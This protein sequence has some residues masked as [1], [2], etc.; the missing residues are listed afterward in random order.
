MAFDAAAYLAQNPDVAAD[1]YYALNP[2]AHWLQH[3]Q[4]EGRTGGTT[5]GATSGGN[6]VPQEVMDYFAGGANQF[7]RYTDSSGYQWIPQ[8][9]GFSGGAGESGDQQFTGYRRGEYAGELNDP[10]RAE[11]TNNYYGTD[12]QYSYTNKDD[13]GWLTP[14]TG[15]LAVASLGLGAQYAAAAGAAEAGA[16]G[17]TYGGAT[18]GGAGL[19]TGA[20]TGADMA[21]FYGGLDGAATLGGGASVGGGAALGAGTSAMGAGAG[22]GYL[23]DATAAGY[24]GLDAAS[25]ST[26]GGG[27]S[28]NGGAALGT[29]ATTPSYL[30]QITK[31]MGGSG[32]T[33]G[34]SGSNLLGLA[35]TLAGAYGGSQGQDASA[36]STRQ[37]PGY[38][39]GPV[40]NDLIPRTQG[41]LATQMP[42]AYDAGN[43]MLAK[44]SGLLGQTAPTTATNPYLRSIADDM[45][46]RTTDLL[47]QNNLAIQ[48]NAVGVGGLGGSRQGVA[49][50]I[51]AG[52]A[53]DSLQGQVAGLY[54][55]AYEGDMNRLRQDWTLGAGL[56]GQGLNTQFSPLQNT[57]QV[58]SPFSGFGS[59]TQSQETGGGWQGALG[60]ALGA[61]QFGK[62]MGWWG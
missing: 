47:G 42:A 23:G 4:Y 7:G 10:F 29:A 50:G 1:P 13:P 6:T 30:D 8:Y 33:G 48:G 11:A 31:L 14:L 53:A 12:G 38:L 24:G 56:M 3:G 45:Q 20:A 55:Q 27:A 18:A 22:A 43:Q 49:Q 58:Y 40:A 2:E 35:T 26:L 25:A 21:A 17:T 57:A 59:T 51:G 9:E 34:M 5:S 60:G 36:T 54:G 15:V 61:A 39:Q 41:L 62:N 16:A 32:G 52:R 37:L 19:G 46:R 28:V 44:G